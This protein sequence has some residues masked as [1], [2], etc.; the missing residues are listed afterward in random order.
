MNRLPKLGEDKP[1]Y[2]SPRQGS[3]TMLRFRSPMSGGTSLQGWLAGQGLPLSSPGRGCPAPTMLRVRSQW[4][5]EPQSNNP[6]IFCNIAVIRRCKTR[7]V[8]HFAIQSVIVTVEQLRQVKP[9]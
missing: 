1:L 7:L 6:M 5:V 8:T 3:P 9:W 4:V 2:L